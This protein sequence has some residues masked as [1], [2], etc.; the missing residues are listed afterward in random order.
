MW[1]NFQVYYWQPRVHYE[2]WPQQNR[3]LVE[4]GLHFEGPQD[5]NYRWAE[6]LAEHV[7]EVQ[8]V[9]GP[10]VELE[11]WTTSW[12]RLHQTL[13]MTELD[14]ELADITADKLAE[15][16]AV[17][18][19]ILEEERSRLGLV[20]TSSPEG[21]VPRRSDHSV[22]GTG[23]EEAIAGLAGRRADRHE[24]HWRRRKPRAAAL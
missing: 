18:Q 13:A 5:E 1:S 23:T 6:R 12:V 17:L 24:R 3:G 4:I 8:S 11:E 19:P 21:V 10:S 15:S 22:E 20:D 16:I 14:P 2:V 9:L 7:L